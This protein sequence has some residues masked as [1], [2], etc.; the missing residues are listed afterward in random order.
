M[1]YNASTLQQEAIF[2]VTPNGDDG[3]IWSAGQ[4]PVADSSGNIYFM[5][6]NGDFTANTGGTDYG[7]SFVKFSGSSLAVSDYFTPDTQATLNVDNSDLGSGGPMLM[8]STSL[9]VGMGKDGILRVVNTTNMGHYSSSTDNDVQEFTATP[10]AFFSS[11]VYWDSPNHGPVIYIWGGADYLKAFQFTGSTFVTTPVSEGT[12]L[13]SSGDPNAA[14]L[15][16]SADGSLL[17]TG[18]LWSTASISQWAK[19]TQVPGVVRA[20]DQSYQRVV[21]QHAKS[22]T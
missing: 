11:P 8:P 22:G 4:G 9:L 14:A 17:G 1:S 20:F 16:I 12:L 6:G 21:G 10:N 7:D 2:N 13:N 19:G 18:V 15:S 5:T 3:G